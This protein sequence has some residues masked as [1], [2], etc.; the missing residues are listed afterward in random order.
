MIFVLVSVI[1]L[2]PHV[3]IIDNNFVLTRHVYELHMRQHLHN[4]IYFLM[5]L[6]FF[7]MGKK[8]LCYVRLNNFILR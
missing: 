4:V 7:P 5:K 3:W 2:L 6:L 1:L 8:E